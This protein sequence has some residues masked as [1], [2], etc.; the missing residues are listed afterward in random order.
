MKRMMP[1]AQTEAADNS[2]DN[3]ETDQNGYTGDKYRKKIRTNEDYLEYQTEK[4]QRAKRT[5]ILTQN[6]FAI[7][8]D[9]VQHG[10]D[11]PLDDPSDVEDN[12]TG[13]PLLKTKHGVYYQSKNIK[14]ESANHKQSRFDSRQRSERPQNGKAEVPNESLFTEGPAYTGRESTSEP[15][16]MSFIDKCHL[17]GERMQAKKDAQA[18]GKKDK[19]RANKK[20]L[21]NNAFVSMAGGGP[22][23][24]NKNPNNNKKTKFGKYHVGSKVHT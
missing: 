10:Q 14:K 12:G 3:E 5:E 9:K 24:G 22:K 23:G 6:K 20:E 4:D 8:E 15:K 19:A 16:G 7:L 21:L 11:A 18:G 1:D 17:I 2:S 13:R